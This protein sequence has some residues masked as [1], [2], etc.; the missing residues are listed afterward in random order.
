[1]VPVLQYGKGK[2]CTKPSS[3][4]LFVLTKSCVGYPKFTEKTSVISARVPRV[5]ASVLGAP[6]TAPSTPTAVDGYPTEILKAW[7]RRW[8]FAGFAGLPLVGSPQIQP[9]YEIST[10]PSIH[11]MRSDRA[12][13]KSPCNNGWGTYPITTLEMESSVRQA[14]EKTGFQNFLSLPCFINANCVENTTES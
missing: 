3:L 2:S 7:R 5:V 12:F 9:C 6:L 4:M 8:I 13:T 1:M 11:E 10:S 14:K